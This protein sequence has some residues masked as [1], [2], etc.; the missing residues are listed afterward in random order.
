MS[1]KRTKISQ[2]TIDEIMVLCK[3]KCCWCE[4]QEATEIHHVDQNPSN[5]KQDNLFPCCSIC[6]KKF[7][8]STDF[9]RRITENELKM[10]RDNFYDTQSNFKAIILRELKEI[11]P[12]TI[13]IEL[14]R[15]K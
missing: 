7:H 10:R 11:K 9:V 4:T 1:K 13:K 2:E 3:R 14:I 8:T 12:S 6:Q 15:K 5:N